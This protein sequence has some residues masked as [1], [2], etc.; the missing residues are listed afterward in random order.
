M[1]TCEDTCAVAP[2]TTRIPEHTNKSTN[3]IETNKRIKQCGCRVKTIWAAFQDL[4]QKQK[5]T[6]KTLH[7][8]TKYI[9]KREST[10]P[11]RV[12]RMLAIPTSFLFSVFVFLQTGLLCVALAVLEFAL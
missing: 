9:F 3:V 11:K 8:D 2:L 10:R 12:K 5:Q 6:N 1:P 4:S 7:K